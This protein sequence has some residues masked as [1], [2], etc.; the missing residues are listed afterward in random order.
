MARRILLVDDDIAAIATVRRALSRE[1]LQVLL[2]TSAADGMVALAHHDPEVVLLA[3]G[4]EGGRGQEVREAISRD[5][6]R[7]R[8]VVLLLGE[9]PGPAFAGDPVFEKP[10]DP[11]AVLAAIRSQFPGEVGSEM[12]SWTMDEPG[13]SL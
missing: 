9:G 2:A 5:R 12:P 8:M 3:P 11:L 13:D 7:D 10:V 1:G 6:R 4:L